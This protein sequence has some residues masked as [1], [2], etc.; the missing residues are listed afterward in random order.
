VKG[1]KTR[2]ALRPGGNEDKILPSAFFTVKAAG[3]KITAQGKGFGHGVGLCQ[4]G[5]LA[6][7][8]ANQNFVQIIR[9]YYQGVDV[10]EFR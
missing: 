4:V 5:A 2:W 7:S 3:G 6:R 9:A 10:V 8:K 1:D